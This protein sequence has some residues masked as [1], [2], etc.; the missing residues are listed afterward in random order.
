MSWSRTLTFVLFTTVTGSFLLGS[1]FGTVPIQNGMI[2]VDVVGCTKLT[3]DTF[4]L[5]NVS[6][7]PNLPMDNTF[8]NRTAWPGKHLHQFKNISFRTESPQKFTNFTP[9]FARIMDQ[10]INFS[11]FRVLQ[12]SGAMQRMKLSFG[13]DFV[14]GVSRSSNIDRR[15][16]T[17][18]QLDQIFGERAAVVWLLNFDAANMT[19][20]DIECMA[21]KARLG[22][23]YTHKGVIAATIGHFAAFYVAVAMNYSRILVVEDDADFDKTAWRVGHYWSKVLEEIPKDFDLIH[24]GAGRGCGGGN[25]HGGWGVKYSTHFWL[26]QGSRCAHAYLVS[27]LGARNMIRSLPIVAEIDSHIN[28]AVGHPYRKSYPRCP[29]PMPPKCPGPPPVPG[30]RIYHLHPPVASLRSTPGKTW[31]K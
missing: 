24:V 8:S 11:Q 19:E 1:F 31:M 30:M 26:A 2:S 29:V 17:Q 25:K 21:P 20:S 14:V 10:R 16:R 15:R 23:S 3:A 4:L 6:T 27:Q 22:W 18:V 9:C 12:A 5:R 13:F 28:Y 7:L